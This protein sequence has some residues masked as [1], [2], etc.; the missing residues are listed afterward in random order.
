MSKVV[1]PW[2]AEVTHAAKLCLLTQAST[3]PV[4]HQQSCL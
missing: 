3:A 1:E 2:S 4:R